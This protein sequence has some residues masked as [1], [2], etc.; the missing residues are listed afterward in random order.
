MC[1]GQ[2]LAN[3]QEVIMSEFKR[4]RNVAK[5]HPELLYYVNLVSTEIFENRVENSL[6]EDTCALFR[7]CQM[8]RFCEAS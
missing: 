8:N 7:V 6:V 2:K 1:E 5:E 3:L 4:V